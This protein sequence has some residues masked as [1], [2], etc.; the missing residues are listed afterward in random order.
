MILQPIRQFHPADQTRCSYKC[1]FFQNGAVMAWC[2]KYG[3]AP[4]YM[5]NIPPLRVSDCVK[6]VTD[7]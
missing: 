2:K 5:G 3:H 1:P 4:R 6:E 7:E